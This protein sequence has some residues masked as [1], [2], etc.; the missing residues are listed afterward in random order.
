MSKAYILAGGEINP[1]FLSN[2]LHSREENTLWIVVDGG[3][4]AWE[5]IHSPYAPDILVGDFDTVSQEL[6]NQYI[7]NHQILII[8]HPP[9]KNA[10]DTELALQIAIERACQEIYILGC[11]GGRMDHT[12]ANI[13]LSTY[14]IKG[15][16]QGIQIFL[17]DSYNKIYAISSLEHMLYQENQYGKYISIYP[18]NGEVNKLTLQ[19]FKY[20][21][22][23][24]KVNLFENPTLTTSN[25]MIEEKASIIWDAGILLVVESKDK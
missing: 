1:V 10:T 3:L 16:Y 5:E 7:I 17:L 9:I 22:Y 15:K 14:A 8:H 11:F 12:L 4:K 19:G 2:I 25:E 23:E 18:L 20:P 21:L 6:L 24:A 13:Y